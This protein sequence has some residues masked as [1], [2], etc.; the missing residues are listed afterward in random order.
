[1]K[2]EQ[3]ILITNTQYCDLVDPEFIGQSRLNQNNQYY[4]IWK[5]GDVYYKTL[6]NL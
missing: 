5:S 6:N 3:C 4:M 1:M 2:L